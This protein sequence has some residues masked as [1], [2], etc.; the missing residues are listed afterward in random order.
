MSVPIL[1]YIGVIVVGTVATAIAIAL[2]SRLTHTHCFLHFVHSNMNHTHCF[3]SLAFVVCFVAF[4]VS[5]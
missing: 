2:C 4:L 5:H 3:F 1:V